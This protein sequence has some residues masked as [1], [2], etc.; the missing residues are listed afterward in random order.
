MSDQHSHTGQTWRLEHDSLGD[1]RVPADRYWGAQTERARHRFQIGNDPIPLELIHAI[2]C[3]KRMAAH[4]NHQLGVLDEQRC[5]WISEAAREVEGGKLDGE[6][7]LSCW[8]S[9]SGT[10]TN[11]NVNEVIAN[12][13]CELAGQARGSRDVVHPND[14][15]NRSQSTNDVFPCAIHLAAERQQRL[16]LLPTLRQLVEALE[17]KAAA[18]DGVVKIGRTHLQ[19][20]VP[21]TVGQEVGGWAAQLRSAAERLEQGLLELRSIPLGGTAVGTGIGA[22]KGYPQAVCEQLS[23]CEGVQWRSDGNRFALMGSH[24]ALVQQMAQ[25][26]LLAGALHKIV[27]DIRLL[28]CGPR[29]GLGELQL[30]ANEPGSSIMPG[31]VN[32]TQCEAVAMATTQVMGMDQAVAI[33][34]SAGHL[35]MNVYKPLL[36]LN[37]LRSGQLLTDS[38]RSLEEHLVR[39]MDL[40]HSKVGHFR[41]QSL[42]LV[43]ALA[44]VIGYDMAAKIALHAHSE[45]LSLKQAALA[46]E[47]IEAEAFDEAVNP[48]WMAK[49]HD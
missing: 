6:F 3:L 15:V 39:G 31:K 21:L 48:G 16:A 5:Q 32:P 1:V 18:W 4:T 14:H 2:A 33:G 35:Q 42:M 28:A 29:A 45:G 19:D 46:L 27:N 37:L 49:P 30:P 26:R 22:P 12:R 43:T 25:L 20:A 24:D 38:C 40:D 17:S 47:A 36:G 13:A 7:P 9:G 10:Q 34:G 23:R 8:Q 41:D 11:M 44:P